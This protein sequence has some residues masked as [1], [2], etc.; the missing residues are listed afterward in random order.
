MARHPDES[1][2]IRAA[3]LRQEL[4]SADY[5]PN[6]RE[7]IRGTVRSEATELAKTG[8]GVHA[9]VPSMPDEAVNT[10]KLA[11]KKYLR[12]KRG[13]KPRPVAEF[14]MWGP[15]RHSSDDAWSLE[16]A[17]AWGGKTVSWVRRHF[18][19]SPI[20]DASLHMD[21]GSPHVHVSIF[22]RYKDRAGEMA[23]GWKRAS[24]AATDRMAGRETQF[25][26]GLQRLREV[27]NAGAAQ[28]V[29]LD[30]YH[31]EACAEFGLARGERGSG[32]KHKAV[33]VD[34][35][36]RR[37]AQD[38]EIALEARERE[39]NERA[40]ARTRELD[41]RAVEQKRLFEERADLVERANAEVEAKRK[42]NEDE[43]KRLV[44]EKA[45]MLA[46]NESWAME[47]MA[48]KNAEAKLREAKRKLAKHENAERLK[49]E[50]AE[51]KRQARWDREN[52]DDARILKGERL[53]EKREAARDETRK[54]RSV[55]PSFQSR[56]KRDNNGR[57]GR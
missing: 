20:L 35:A 43:E 51:A 27:E 19:D 44:N 1:R 38:R 34:E 11:R 26:G 5:L 41:E 30:S 31:A 9:L 48:R 13:R 24:V 4:V 16:K 28:S 8:G 56:S 53:R 33:T 42:E 40:D 29:L 39:F 47:H 25:N 15:P 12:T 46:E 10:L 36:S 57:D 37:H 22:P 17:K 3:G 32:R 54:R 18:P 55:F 7:H 23:Y 21:E 49:R 45:R 14:V 2:P 52:A 6:R 50:D